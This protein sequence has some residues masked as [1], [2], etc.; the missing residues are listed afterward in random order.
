[1]DAGKMGKEDRGG[2][3]KL[4]GDHQGD[5]QNPMDATGPNSGGSQ[6][7]APVSD[8][9]MALKILE[10]APEAV[11]CVDREGRIVYLN[12]AAEKLWGRPKQEACGTDI[13][14][15]LVPEPHREHFRKAFPSMVADAGQEA[16]GRSH[17]FP[18]TG[19]DGTPFTAEVSL[20]AFTAGGEKYYLAL[21]RDVTDQQKVEESL[22]ETRERYRILHDNAGYAVFSYNRDLILNGVNRVVTELL[23]Y[24]EEELLGR[25]VLELG[26]LHPDDYPRVAAAMGMLFT[27]HSATREDLRFIRK[28]GALIIAHVIGVP[29]FDKRGEL[30][31]V[32]NIA[33][34]VTEQRRLEE[35]LEAH[36]RNLENTVKERTR[37]LQETL[38]ELDRSERYFRALIE[39]TYDLI[40]VLDENLNI[41]YLSP[42]VES[43]SGYTPEE[44]IGKNALDFIHPEDLPPLVEKFTSQLN[45]TGVTERSEYRWRHKDGTYR[46]QEAVACNLLDDPAVKGIVVNARDIT[47]HKETERALRE[48]EE[49]YR[50]LV[51]TSPDAIVVTDFSGWIIMANPAAVEILGCRGL[52]EVVGRNVLEFIAL[53]D[54]ARAV[55]SM[56]TPT[57]GERVRREEYILVRKD[58]PRRWVEISASLL[59]DEFGK[60]LGFISITRDITETKQV[61]M[62]LERLNRSLLSLGHDPLENIPNIVLAGR[63]ILNAQIARYGRKEGGIFQVFSSREAE[64]GFLPRQDTKD[65]ICYQLLEKG[66]HSPVSRKDLDLSLLEKDPD[67]ALFRPREILAYPIHIKGKPVGCLCFFFQEERSFSAADIDIL[68][69]LGRAI[70]IEEDRWDYQESLRDFIDVASHELRHPTALLSGYAQLL[71]ERFDELDP[72]TRREVI[73]ALSSSTARLAQIADGLVR[74]SLVERG[75]LPLNRS[76]QDP[77]QLVQRAISEMEIRFP[78]RVF[79]LAVRGETGSCSLDPVRISELLTFLL[80]NAVKFSPPETEVEVEVEAAPQGIQVSVLDRG[81]GVEAE[82]R[83]RIFERFY[84]EEKAL[85]HSEGL[86]LGLYLARCIAEAH[87]GRIWYEPRPGGGSVFRFF[88]PYL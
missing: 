7:R 34:D 16:P 47:E 20:T 44:V 74:T 78:G 32:L 71:K 45:S 21:I 29:L 58:G 61:R 57:K 33:H 46:W 69:M 8:A 66:I 31:E 49:R 5:P 38:Q 36:R 70:A 18:S 60:P 73:E 53:E 65:Y 50:S 37:E 15:L 48:S 35:Q 62:N 25:N 81:K 63:E 26:V 27:G 1:M 17:R 87:G 54:H 22:R 3:K 41:R 85:Y 76:R 88:L 28:D 24:R 42:S 52:E 59:R 43:I 84:Q 55:K 19:K 2:K 64:K 80:D 72:P 79:R 83:E 6:S 56:R 11:V 9:E 23:G 68:I 10:A 86:G 40:A 77:V 30:V 14:S 13:A 82:N 12:P 67:A 51:E 4:P 75:Q 39:N